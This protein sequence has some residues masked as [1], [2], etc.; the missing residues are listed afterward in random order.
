MEAQY[1]TILFSH[2]PD[3]YTATESD[4]TSIVRQIRTKYKPN[5]GRRIFAT[6]KPFCKFLNNPSSKIILEAKQPAQDQMTVQAAMI[7]TDEDIQK[8][9]ESCTKDR[10]RDLFMKLYDG[11][12]RPVDAVSLNWGNISFEGDMAIVNVN[13]KTG[14]PRYIPLGL[15]RPYLALWKAN[16]PTGEATDDKPV[17]VKLKQPYPRLK[18]HSVKTVLSPIVQKAGMDDKRVFPYLFRHSSVTNKRR[19]GLPDRVISAMHWGHASRM[20]DRY[21]HVSSEDV[22]SGVMKLHGIEAG[23]AKKWKYVSMKV[24]ECPRCHTTNAPTWAFCSSCGFSLTREAA[25]TQNETIVS[26]EGLLATSQGEEMIKK[27]IR[28]MAEKGE[29]KG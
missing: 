25:E 10:D 11:G 7:L 24:R 5:T 9:I 18:S 26:L 12:L 13:Q 4:F 1:H 2:I 21:D 17:F 19:Q 6:L 28:E 15:A 27:V 3:P 14:I 20:M 29:L 22:L 8:I 23:E 16:Y